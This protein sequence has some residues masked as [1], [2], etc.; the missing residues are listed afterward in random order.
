MKLNLSRPIIFFDIESTGLNVATDRIVELCTIKVYPD[1]REETRTLRFNPEIPISAEAIAVNG[2]TNA[3]V[4][5]C[6]TFK[7]KANELADFFR[8]SDFAGFNSNFFDVP[9]LV[10]EFIRAGI[11]FDVTKVRF[12]DV[13]NIYHKMEKRNLAAAYKFYC[14]KDLEN[15]H[16]A[17]ADTRATYEVLQ[18]Q[19]ERYDGELENNVGF[20]SD[21]SRHNRNVDLAG[22][23][24]LNERG[25]ETINFGKNK[26]KS[27]AEVLRRD[28]GYYSWIQ[29]GDFTQNTKQI[30]MRLKLKYIG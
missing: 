27:V 11:D 3:D 7:E 18:A 24:V 14:N 28:P 6:P 13:Q 29:Q 17:E 16:T 4:A 1:G 30:F 2:I 21:F 15:A 8:D 5:D 20:L 9:L 22:R 12:I 10:E 23:I 19:L 25:V 26:G